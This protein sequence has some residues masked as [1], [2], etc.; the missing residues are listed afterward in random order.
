LLFYSTQ[1]PCA[2]LH[3]PPIG[4]RRKLAA[5]R[6]TSMPLNMIHAVREVAARDQETRAT[7]AH[8]LH[9]GQVRR[10]GDLARAMMDQ[11]STMHPL[12]CGP[13]PS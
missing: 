9:D 10:C 2:T 6:S 8:R 12:I 13:T 1:R 11:L 7:V 3:E 4:D 5:Q